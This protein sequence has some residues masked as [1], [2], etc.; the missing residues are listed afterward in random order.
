MFFFYFLESQVY[1]DSKLGIITNVGRRRLLK[2]IFTN[3]HKMSDACVSNFG[4][5]MKGLIY[6]T[7]Y[8]KCFYPPALQ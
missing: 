6:C 4:R 2:I 7:M 1:K 5:Q 3:I 8:K